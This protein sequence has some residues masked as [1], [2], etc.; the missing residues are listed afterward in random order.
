MEN[1]VITIRLNYL[2]LLIKNNY[3]INSENGLFYFKA[4]YTLKVID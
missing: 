2:P 4:S 1:E 3:Q